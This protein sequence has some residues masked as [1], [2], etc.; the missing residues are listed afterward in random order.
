MNELFI[1]KV[2]SQDN[3]LLSGDVLDLFTRQI[4]NGYF[5][6]LGSHSKPTS[7]A[8][9]SKNDLTAAADSSNSPELCSWLSSSS[10]FPV[11]SISTTKQFC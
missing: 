4:S 6:P 11:N 9:L 3:F 7:H 1:A 2:A 10:N 8:L 5:F